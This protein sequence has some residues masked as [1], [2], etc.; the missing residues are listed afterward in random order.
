[1]SEII[2]RKYIFEKLNELTKNLKYFYYQGAV[3]SLAE[4]FEMFFLWFKIKNLYNVKEYKI[5]LECFVNNIFINDK[6]LNENLWVQI[7]YFSIKKDENYMDQ[8]Y[9]FTSTTLRSL[10]KSYFEKEFL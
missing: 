2:I 10:Q 8:S 1:M 5:N 4:T 3:N 7:C 6:N 9:F